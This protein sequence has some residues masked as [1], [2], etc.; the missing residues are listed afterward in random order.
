MGRAL[1]PIRASTLRNTGEMG[2]AAQC[3][4]FIEHSPRL[5]RSPRYV[6]E[7]VEPLE[8]TDALDSHPRSIHVID[9][10]DPDLASKLISLLG[11]PPR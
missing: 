9:W 10:A 7:A 3:L 1:S 4:R 5:R 11:E 2:S 6:L 8:P